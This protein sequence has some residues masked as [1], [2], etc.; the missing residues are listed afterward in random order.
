MLFRPTRRRIVGRGYRA[1]L[2][3][4]SLLLLS[5]P[6]FAAAFT[7]AA[8]QDSPRPARPAVDL[9]DMRVRTQP[10]ARVMK[11]GRQAS[12]RFER[13]VRLVEDV[14]V[15]A[16]VDGIAQNLARHSDVTVPITIKVV[17]SM[18]VNGVSFP[19]GFL[20]VTTGLI[21]AMDDEA[22]IA[23]VVAHEIAHVVARDGLRDNWYLG[24]GGG[25]GS[26]G[27]LSD[28]LFTPLESVKI[29]REIEADNQAI[30]YM[31]LAGYDPEALI[32]FLE[33][34][35]A[36]ELTERNAVVRMPHTHPAAPERIQL[37]RDQIEAVP[38]TNSSR[39]DTTNELR[40][41]QTRL[42]EYEAMRLLP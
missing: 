4:G 29:P 11:I 5:V 19:G 7:A 13:G 39:T 25:P 3:A 32:R 31:Q 37:A 2:V 16:Y 35:N 8:R 34:L 20:Y 36:R 28:G 21:L 15:Q 6:A 12:R 18:E 41:I 23:S 42:L 40:K 33:K 17:D 10:P 26:R 1:G 30:Q 27:F 14:A 22:E 24:T 9:N 38:P